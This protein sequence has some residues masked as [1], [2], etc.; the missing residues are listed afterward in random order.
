MPAGEP[1]AEVVS[2]REDSRGALSPDGKLIAFNSDRDG[3]MNI[4]LHD[5][6]SGSDRQLT[7]GTGGD[8]Q[9]AWS[10]DGAKIAFFSSRSSTPEIWSVDVAT[11]AL[12]ELTREGGISTSPKY[13]PDG[14]TIAFQSDRGGRTELWAMDASGANARQLTHVGVVGHFIAWTSDGAHVTFISAQ[15]DRRV[16]MQ[17]AIDGGEPTLMPDIKG[18]AHISFSP[19]FE[20]I[21]DVVG[22]R[23]LWVS[24]VDGGAPAKVF[25]FADPN[26]RIDFPTWMHDG[27]GILFDRFRPEGGDVWIAEGFE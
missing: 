8:Y 19:D 23:T 5:R 24:P 2:T 17:I 25:E 13:S 22:H 18:G 1:R 20:R 7:R 11:G 6:A 16:R 21:M 10:P 26:V 3:E 12:V 4:W 15:G 9:P 27:S 14:K